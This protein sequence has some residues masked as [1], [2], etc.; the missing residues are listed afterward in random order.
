MHT[1]D[2]MGCKEIGIATAFNG[3]EDTGRYWGAK[4]L[5]LVNMLTQS[6]A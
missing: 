1:K 2:D 6:G 3:N 5:G 4:E